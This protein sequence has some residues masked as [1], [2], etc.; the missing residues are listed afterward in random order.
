[1]EQSVTLL[2]LPRPHRSL[3]RATF[4]QHFLPSFER[5]LEHSMF[6]CSVL[7]ESHFLF[8]FLSTDRWFCSK[9]SNP[10]LRMVENM[11]DNS[12][13]SDYPNDPYKRKHLF[14]DVIKRVEFRSRDTCVWKEILLSRKPTPWKILARPGISY[15]GFL[16]LLWNCRSARRQI[17]WTSP[18]VNK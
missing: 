3:E 9:A 5:H 13:Q 2:H 10:L 15:C 18:F 17:E 7:E 16:I 14:M 8:T 6:L 4:G 12:L 11:T 1:M